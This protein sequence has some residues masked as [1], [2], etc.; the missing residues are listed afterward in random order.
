ME[1]KERTYDLMTLGFHTGVYALAGM[2]A[3]DAPAGD[4][5]SRVQFE[6]LKENAAREVEKLS[7][8]P[9]EDF[10]SKVE[11][12]LTEVTKKDQH[13]NVKLFELMDELPIKVKAELSGQNGSLG[14]KTIIVD[15]LDGMY[16]YC[17]PE[18]DPKT[19][20]HLHIG[21]P[22]VKEGEFYRINPDE[23]L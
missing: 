4:N 11:G 15:H 22:L 8:M 13:G 18:D 5:P 6:L 9:A 14:E 3:D 20:V 19:I 17:Y 2:L 16:S 23:G 10:A 21:T 12:L 1:D 7:G